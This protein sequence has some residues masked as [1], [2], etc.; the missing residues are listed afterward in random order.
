MAEPFQRSELMKPAIWKRMAIVTLMKR[1]SMRSAKET[2]AEFFFFVLLF[3][4]GM[5]ALSGCDTPHQGVTNSLGLD[6]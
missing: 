5:P 6:Y 1:D 3:S 2:K 4:L